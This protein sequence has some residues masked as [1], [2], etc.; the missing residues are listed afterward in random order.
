VLQALWQ[1]L[2]LFSEETDVPLA[3]QMTS[4][5]ERLQNTIKR[6]HS[7]NEISTT[8][9]VQILEFTRQGIF[10]HL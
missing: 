10:G 6:L 5:Y 7:E 1:T 9:V 4:R 8:Q 3:T 2:D